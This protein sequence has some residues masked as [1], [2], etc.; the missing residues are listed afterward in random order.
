MKW[1]TEELIFKWGCIFACVAALA[2]MAW[3]VC[4]YVN[5]WE[6]EPHQTVEQYSAM[7]QE[8]ENIKSDY[9]VE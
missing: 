9:G 5:K 7:V 1:E 4:D 8:R 3:C 2:F 6:P